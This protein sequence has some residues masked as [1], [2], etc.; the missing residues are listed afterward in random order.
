VVSGLKPVENTQLA[1]KI[2]PVI[3]RYTGA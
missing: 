1:E 2:A 3:R